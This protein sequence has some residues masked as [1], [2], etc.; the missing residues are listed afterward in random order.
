VKSSPSLRLDPRSLP[1]HALSFFVALGLW[2]YV[3]NTVET[4]ERQLV[5]LPSVAG[6]SKEFIVA[7]LENHRLPLLLRGRRET[8]QTLTPGTVAAYLDFTD[9]AVREPGQYRVPVRLADLPDGVSIV[10]APQVLAVRLDR[11][12][13]LT[14]RVVISYGSRIPPDIK[15]LSAATEPA[16]VTISGPASVLARVHSAV[17]DID[18]G[19]LPLSAGRDFPVSILDSRKNPIP[20]LTIQPSSVKFIARIERIRTAKV[21]AVEPDVRGVPA[22]GY[23]IS[24]IRTEPST[25][26]LQG[27]P[28]HM[29]LIQGVSTPPIHITNH[30][31]SIKFK[32]VPLVLP[33]YVTSDTTKVLVSVEIRPLK[34]RQDFNVP[35]TLQLP[36]GWSGS[37][38]PSAVTVTLEAFSVA[39]QRL[40]PGS[41]VASVHITTPERNTFTQRVSVKAP[42]NF[43]VVSVSPDRVEVTLSSNG[44][45]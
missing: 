41:I 12:S 10:S 42:D 7:D 31:R 6:L 13:R 36:P 45:A 30:S 32:D 19:A 16:E 34:I 14:R 4:L 1:L 29:A 35:V 22:S 11:M 2:V 43:S 26:L 44:S 23:T 39:F 21:V 38:S 24:A 25:I 40:A 15:V 8:I 3:R 5:V 18:S 37:S 27:D 9:I 20:N 28:S 17:I 33:P